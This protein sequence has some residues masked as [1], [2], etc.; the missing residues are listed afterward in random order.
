MRRREGR[1]CKALLRRRASICS[2]AALPA[3]APALRMQAVEVPAVRPLELRVRYTDVPRDRAGSLASVM[4][5]DR[6]AQPSCRGCK[7]PADPEKARSAPLQM[8]VTS[9]GEE[10]V[11]RPAQTGAGP[12]GAWQ[13]SL[14]M[15]PPVSCPISSRADGVAPELFAA[16]TGRSYNS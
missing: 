4:E 11:C 12:A 6:P 5:A 13:T 15:A 3:A 7:G 14:A 1:V 10:R 2:R 16:T 8:A 9:R